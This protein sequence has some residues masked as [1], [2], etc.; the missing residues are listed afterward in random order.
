MNKV[1]I[2]YLAMGFASL[3]CA[4]QYLID[5]KDTSSLQVEEAKEGPQLLKR[6]TSTCLA[7]LFQKKRTDHIATIIYKKDSVHAS[8]ALYCASK[9]K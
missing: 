9:I 6:M 5:F 3:I 2:K 1:I 8:L 7:C 4:A